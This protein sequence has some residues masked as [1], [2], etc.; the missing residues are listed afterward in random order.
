MSRQF[1]RDIRRY[2]CALCLTRLQANE[3]TFPSGPSAFTTHVNRIGSWG[4]TGIWRTGI[5]RT[6]KWKSNATEIWSCY[7]QITWKTY[8]S[9]ATENCGKHE[10]SQ[11]QVEIRLPESQWTP[12]T[13]QQCI[14]FS[15]CNLSHF[16]M[17]YIQRYLKFAATCTRVIVNFIVKSRK[18]ASCVI[19]MLRE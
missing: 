1:R 17:E 10:Q 8:R 12:V 7:D 5:W 4:V 14:S 2:N 15:N 11:P 18:M 19:W 16:A 13:E 3:V 9:G 6:V